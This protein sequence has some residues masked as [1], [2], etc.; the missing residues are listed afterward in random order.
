MDQIIFPPPGQR[1]DDALPRQGLG[2]A[3]AFF[4]MD[5][6]NGTTGPRIA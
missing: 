6:N 3:A 1:L 4:L 5:E 2:P